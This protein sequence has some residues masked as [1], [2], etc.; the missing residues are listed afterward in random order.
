VQTV[1]D[2]KKDIVLGDLHENGQQLRPH[3]VWFGEEVPAMETAIELVER[4]DVLLIVGTSLQV[5]PAAGLRNYILPHVHTYLVDTAPAL[6][7]TNRL[8]V[9]AKKASEGVRE[10][11]DLLSNF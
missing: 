11:A 7:S 9:I 10:V 2:W 1:V 4:A 6:N 5:Y 8:T 3:I